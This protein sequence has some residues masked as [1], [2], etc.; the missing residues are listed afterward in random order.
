LSLSRPGRFTPRERAPVTHWIGGW[1]GLR[2]GLDT[3][4]KREILSSSRES[5]P[6]S[7][8]RSS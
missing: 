5:N 7:S 6:R 1:G 8:S 3:V 4:V 2:T